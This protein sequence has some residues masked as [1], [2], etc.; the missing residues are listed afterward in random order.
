MARPER[1]LVEVAVHILLGDVDVRP[2]HGRLEQPPEALDRIGV[3]R[4]AV[5]VVVVGVF[6]SSSVETVEPAS[7]FFGVTPRSVSFWTFGITSARTRPP[8]SA[9]PMTIVLPGAPRPR[10]PPERLPP[11]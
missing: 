3:V 8:R 9:M 5:A 1:K 6:L 4:R 11:T 7:T 2:A 10:L